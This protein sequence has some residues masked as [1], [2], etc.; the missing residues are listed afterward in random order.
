MPVSVCV[1]LSLF[2]TM[3]INSHS[4]PLGCSQIPSQLP[5]PSLPIDFTQPSVEPDSILAL[6]SEALTC[7]SQSSIREGTINEVDETIIKEQVIPILIIPICN[8]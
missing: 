4:F 5:P 8:I 6:N 1:C 7:T 2:F 3:T